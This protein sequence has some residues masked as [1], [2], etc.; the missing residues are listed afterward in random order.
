MGTDS[1]SGQHQV[2]I[3]QDETKRQPYRNTAFWTLRSRSYSRTSPCPS[4]S[5]T[6]SPWGSPPWG[7]SPCRCPFCCYPHP[8][9]WFPWS[10]CSP[11]CCPPCSS[12][13]SCSPPCSPPSC[14]SPSRSPC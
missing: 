12:P 10:P 8:P 3:N 5:T 4:P 14:S 6:L 9:C 1:F 11:P 2:N 13:P 7:F